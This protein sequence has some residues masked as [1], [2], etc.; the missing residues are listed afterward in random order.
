[1]HQSPSAQAAIRRTGGVPF[2]LVSYA[3]ELRL[4]QSRTVA[5]DDV[6]W[7][8]AH[9]VRQRVAA[10][11]APAQEL[12]RVASVVGRTAPRALL[13]AVV[14]RPD[15]DVLTALDAAHQARLLVEEGPYAYQFAHD[16]IREVVEA[17]LGAARRSCCIAS[18]PRRWRRRPGTSRSSSWPTISRAATSPTGP[19]P[20]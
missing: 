12:L 15:G 5:V 11:P 8:V 9:S 7:S 19:F 14:A 3:H 20:T 4:Q 2:Y 18:S 16:V 10:L 17:D 6:P 1:M 13:S